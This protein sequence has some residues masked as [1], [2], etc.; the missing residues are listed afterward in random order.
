M[1]TFWRYRLAE[2]LTGRDGVE[3]AHVSCVVL[4]ADEVDESLRLDAEMHEGSGWNVTI[5]GEGVGTVVVA[6]KGPITRTMYAV[7]EDPLAVLTP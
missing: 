6:R 3:R 4:G 5:G 1:T 2:K 7:R